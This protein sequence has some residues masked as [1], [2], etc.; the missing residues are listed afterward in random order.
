M[1]AFGPVALAQ[2]FA[3][4][5]CHDATFVDGRIAYRATDAMTI[6]GSLR[7][8][9]NDGSFS[10]DRQDNKLFI[11]YQLPQNY[12]IRLSYQHVDYNEDLEVYDV[13]IVEIAFGLR[14]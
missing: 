8:Y 12:R 1:L 13:D 6:G 7:N 14:W 3:C 11:D 4:T 9:D 2:D 5:T 10:S